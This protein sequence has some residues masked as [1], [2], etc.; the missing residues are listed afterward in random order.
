MIVPDTNLLLYAYDVGS[1]RH[2]EAQTWLDAV[3]DGDEMIGLPWQ[4]AWAFIRISTNPRIAVESYGMEQA[5]AIVDGWMRQSR[6]KLLLPGERHW[7]LLKKMLVEGQVRG[8][9]VTDA[10]LAAITIE[11]G[12]VL[13]TTDRGFARFPGLRWANPLR[14][15]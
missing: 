8:G 11:Y 7:E 15:S 10:E 1:A 6:V 3:F 13:H 5:L 4:V 2:R 14:P 9:G 12:G